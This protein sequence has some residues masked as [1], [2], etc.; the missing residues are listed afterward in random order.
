M[1]ESTLIVILSLAFILTVLLIIRL[2]SK[3]RIANYTIDLLKLQKENVEETLQEQRLY[4]ANYKENA[5]QAIQ[6][7]RVRLNLAEDRIKAQV[8]TIKNQHAQMFELAK[9]TTETLVEKGIIDNRLA[10]VEDKATKYDLVKAKRKLKLLEEWFIEQKY[11]QNS[12][13]L[14]LLYEIFITVK[15]DW[16]LPIPAIFDVTTKPSRKSTKK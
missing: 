15:L 5:E 3:L 7:M 2:F 8:D 6:A 10:A 9:Q 14:E 13:P 11:N 16:S 1:I 4:I 12:T